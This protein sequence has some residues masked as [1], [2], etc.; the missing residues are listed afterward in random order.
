MKYIVRVTDG[1]CVC[2]I[3]IETD[4]G[5]EEACSLAMNRATQ[6]EQ[7]GDR[8]CWEAFE[9]SGR[10]EY[11]DCISADDN[12]LDVPIVYRS[13]TSATCCRRS[14]S[15]K[16]RSSAFRTRDEPLIGQSYKVSFR[17]AI[18]RPSQSDRCTLNER[19]FSSRYLPGASTF[20]EGPFK[21]R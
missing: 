19:T 15:C 7:A 8:C 12:L 5:V 10:A 20:F 14:R 18:G 11:V 6:I 4:N 16:P 13:H 2:D 9:S 17:R 21:C 3:E 1:H